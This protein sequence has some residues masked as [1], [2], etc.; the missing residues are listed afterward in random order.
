MF[1]LDEFKLFFDST[2][3][4]RNIKKM[5]IENAHSQPNYPKYFWMS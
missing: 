3:R 2:K 4:N 1:D 5:L